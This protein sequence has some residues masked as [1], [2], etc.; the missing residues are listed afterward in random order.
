MLYDPFWGMTGIWWI[1]WIIALLALFTFA[2]PVP[3]RTWREYHAT[4]PLALLQKRYAAGEIS[5]QEYEERKAIL[6]RDAVAPPY[7]NRQGPP[8]GT[9]LSGASRPT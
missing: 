8:R 6:E 4:T 3:R 5:T 2:V 9:P 7:A 1:F